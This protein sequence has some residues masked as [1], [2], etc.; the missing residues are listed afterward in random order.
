M[1]GVAG[2]TIGP[3]GSVDFEDLVRRFSEGGYFVDKDFIAGEEAIWTEGT[4]SGFGT[5]MNLP[6]VS[7]GC[8]AC[9]ARAA[10]LPAAP[11]GRVRLG[12]L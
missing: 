9:C 12:N 8:L 1:R 11:S 7:V 6:K 10:M 4:R 5:I 2:C 3:A